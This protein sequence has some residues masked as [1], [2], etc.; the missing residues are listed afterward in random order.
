M[1]KDG[2]IEHHRLQYILAEGD[3]NNIEK[4]LVDD[5]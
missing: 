2:E 5:K 4:Q 1:F 3:I